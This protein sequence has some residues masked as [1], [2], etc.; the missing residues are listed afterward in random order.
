[1]MDTCPCV[2]GVSA[3]EL[4]QRALRD[5]EARIRQALARLQDKR[6]LLRKLR[7]KREF[8]V[9]SVV[10]YTNSGEGLRGRV[11]HTWAWAPALGGHS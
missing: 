7:T 4:R 6:D 2:A 10:G 3:T 11:G 8:P 1:M 5:R 9:V